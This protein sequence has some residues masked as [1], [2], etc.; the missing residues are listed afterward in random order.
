MSF[1]PSIS[2]PAM[3]LAAARRHAAEN[4]QGQEQAGYLADIPAVSQ[5]AYYQKDY[6]KSHKQKDQA[7]FGIGLSPKRGSGVPH[8]AKTTVS[9]GI[10]P[11]TYNS[12][13]P[14]VMDVTVVKNGKSCQGRQN[15]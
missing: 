8:T 11:G 5:N 3:V 12:R 9:K 7:R 10:S 6:G 2:F 15:Q 1:A 4:P 13:A 14:M